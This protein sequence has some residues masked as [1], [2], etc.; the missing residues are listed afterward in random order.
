VAFVK[1]AYL[2]QASAYIDWGD[3][4][5]IIYDLRKGGKIIAGS[6]FRIEKNFWSKESLI[7]NV[8]CNLPPTFFDFNLLE[9]SR[10]G[11]ITGKFFDN[12]RTNVRKFLFNSFCRS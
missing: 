9:T 11:V 7:T 4:D 12:I 3:L 2:V 6:N 10:V 1:R 5:N 8:D